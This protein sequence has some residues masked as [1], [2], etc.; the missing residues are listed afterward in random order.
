MDALKE[1]VG[2]TDAQAQQLRDLRKQQFQ[3]AKPTFEQLRDKRQAL[4]EAMKAED[5]NPAQ[6]G[7]LMVDMKKLGQT[8]RATQTENRAKAQEILTPEQK[9]KL[10]ELQQAGRK[11]MA[12]RQAMAAGLLAP[13]ERGEWGAGMPGA[14]MQRGKMRMK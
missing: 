10:Q 6:V 8:M 1:A 5:P 14:V 3:A 7:Q 9:G 12:A 11:G 4:A 13:P 2:L